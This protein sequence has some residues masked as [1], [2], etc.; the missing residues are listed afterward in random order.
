MRKRVSLVALLLAVAASPGAAEEIHKTYHETFPSHEGTRLDLRHGDGDVTVQVWDK[1]EV[2]IDVEYHATVHAVGAG[3]KGDFSVEFSTEGDTIHV[4]DHEGDVAW[5]GVYVSS[6]TN[7]HRYEIRMPA[8]VRLDTRGD[9]GDVEIEGVRGELRCELGDGDIT[10]R[11]VTS[12]TVQVELGDGDLDARGLTGRLDIDVQD[13]HVRLVETMGPGGRIGVS[14]GTLKMTKCAG[15]FE[16]AA[17][18]GDIHLIAHRGRSLHVTI[19]DG[20]VDLELLPVDDLDVDVQAHDGDVDLLLARGTSASFLIT[21]N[22]GSVRVSH[23]DLS[24]FEESDR[25]AYGEIGPGKGKI[26]VR[27]EDGTVRLRES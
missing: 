18:D 22:D 17:Q 26:R 10:L 13:G 7:K 24:K 19:G 27:C 1:D 11:N 23:P 12:P 21:T 5:V 8:Y 16:I 3:K 2:Q 4:V 15:D 25:G 14:D 9:D 6:R 20:D